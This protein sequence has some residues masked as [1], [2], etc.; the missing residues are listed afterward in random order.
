M[1]TRTFNGSCVASRPTAS[2]TASPWVPML[3]VNSLC[4]GSGTDGSQTRRWREVDSNFRFRVRCKC[5]LRRKSPASAA[6]RR[7]SSAAAVGGHQLGRKAKSRNRTLAAR[8]TG[9]SN[10]PPSSEESVANSVFP[11]AGPRASFRRQHHHRSHIRASDCREQQMR[12]APPDLQASS[13]LVEAANGIPSTSLARRSAVSAAP[14]LRY[15]N[16]C[17]QR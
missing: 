6:C 14:P 10:P 9:S 3:R 5:G 11:K 15:P 2:M 4:H 8:R 12:L 16:G 1:P 17:E 13:S 7:R